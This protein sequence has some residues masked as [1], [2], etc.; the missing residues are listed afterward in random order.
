MMKTFAVMFLVLSFLNIPIYV[1][2]AGNTT[3]NDYG[4]FNNFFRYFSIGNLG[5]MSKFCGWSNFDY[6]FD[7]SADMPPQMVSVDCGDG[8]IGE[9]KEFG[10]LYDFDKKWGGESEGGP[11]C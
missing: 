6:K 2:Y 9:L 11:T 8:Y 5:Q 10:F 1:T 4:N 7:A 3:G